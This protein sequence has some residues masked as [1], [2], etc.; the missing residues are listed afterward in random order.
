MVEMH[1]KHRRKW[2]VQYNYLKL[3]F[4]WHPDTNFIPAIGKYVF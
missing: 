2:R 1:L 4:A 3:L